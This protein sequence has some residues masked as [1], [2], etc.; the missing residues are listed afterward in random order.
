MYILLRYLET[1][2]L[3][4]ITCTMTSIQSESSVK[5]IWSILQVMNNSPQFKNDKVISMIIQTVQY[6]VI[7]IAIEIKVG[8]NINTNCKT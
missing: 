7:L 8:T 3:Q 6:N 2:L 5:T 4:T 1:F